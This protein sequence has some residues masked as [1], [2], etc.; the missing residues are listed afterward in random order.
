MAM[1][2]GIHSVTLLKY[3]GRSGAG[4]AETPSGAKAGVAMNKCEP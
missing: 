1:L 4:E 2:S 3:S